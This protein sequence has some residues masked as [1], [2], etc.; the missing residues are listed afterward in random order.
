MREG[1][2]ERIPGRLCVVSTEPNAELDRRNLELMAWAEM[3]RR[4]L[5]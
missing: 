5:N 3:K 2:R 1:Q 4:L